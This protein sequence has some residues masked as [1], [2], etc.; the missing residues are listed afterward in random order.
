MVRYYQAKGTKNKFSSEDLAQALD[1]LIQK[2]GSIRKTAAA[3]GIPYSTLR[4]HHKGVSKKRYAGRPTVLTYQEEKEI[5]QTCIVLQEMGFPLDKSSLGSVVSDYIKATARDNPFAA[6]YPGPDWFSGF[7]KRWKNTLSQRKP[8]HLSKK[9]AGALTKERVE[10]W[11]EFVEK[12]YRKAGLF[13]LS[14]KEL[15]RRLWNC[16]ETA[17]ATAS[18]SKSVIAKRGSKSVYETMAGSGREHITVHWCGNVN[19]DQI[20]P[21][22]LYKAQHLYHIWT[23]NGP[24]DCTCGV[25][26]SGWMEK[27]NFYSWFVK[28]FLPQVRKLKMIPPKPAKESQPSTLVDTSAIDCSEGSKDT[29]DNPGVILFFDGHYSHISLEVINVARENNI[30]LVTLPPNT[31]HAL[32]PLDVGVFGPMKRCWQKLLTDHKRKTRGKG[33]DKVVFPRLLKQLSDTSM[34]RHH[35]EGAFR[36][37]G[38]YPRPEAAAIPQSK[39][40]P[41]EAV[42]KAKSSTNSPRPSEATQSSTN[43]PR[44]GTPAVKFHLKH[45]FSKLFRTSMTPIRSS[46]PKPSSRVDL[47]YYGEVITSHE[48][49]TRITQ[50]EERNVRQRLQKFRETKASNLRVDKQAN[51]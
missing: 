14:R 43:S 49:C 15:S 25:S 28:G 46:R 39:L 33:I 6:D 51:V 48:A 17:F 5:V 29:A 40:A 11:M 41:S 37:S 50:Q 16:E 9:R 47:A 23:H 18:S 35:F 42:K 30:T 10:G 44:S 19:G 2:K 38:L 1:D 31:T 4:D 26:S 12:V 21:Y 13:R 27:P 3:Y 7:M 8:Q 24:T 32:Q 36:G 20:P 34:K 22:V 45:H